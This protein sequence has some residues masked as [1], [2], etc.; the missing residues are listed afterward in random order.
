[1]GWEIQNIR[2]NKDLFMKAN[3]I[4]VRNQTYNLITKEN[5]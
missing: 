2:N 3:L 1:M 5:K 4:K